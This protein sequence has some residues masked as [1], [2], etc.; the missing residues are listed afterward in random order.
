MG[1]LTEEEESDEEDLAESV[2]LSAFGSSLVFSS[3]LFVVLLSLFEFLRSRKFLR[4]V[5]QV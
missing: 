1:P 2:S 3:I 4:I 5:Y